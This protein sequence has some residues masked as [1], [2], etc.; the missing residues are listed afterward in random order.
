ML[1]NLPEFAVNKPRIPCSTFQRVFFFQGVFIWE[2]HF[3]FCRPDRVCH[4]QGLSLW[5][6]FQNAATAVT[7]LYKGMTNDSPLYT[8]HYWANFNMLKK[9][10]NSGYGY[11]YFILKVNSVLTNKNDWIFTG[12]FKRSQKAWTHISGATSSGS[13]RV[14]RDATRKSWPG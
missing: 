7:N 13:K 14:S 4:Q 12:Y 11:S 5:A 3:Y 6:P 1:K 2:S 9:P 10:N 8:G